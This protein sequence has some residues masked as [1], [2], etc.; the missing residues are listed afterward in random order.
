MKINNTLHY[1]TPCSSVLLSF[2]ISMFANVKYV[3]GLMRR[4]FFSELGLQE[5]LM[6]PLPKNWKPCKTKDTEDI[7][8]FNFSTG[9][10]TWDHPCDGYYK[11]LYEEEKKKKETMKKESNDM[12]RTE[13]KKTVEKLTGKADRKKK[14]KEQKDSVQNSSDSLGSIQSKSASSLTKKPLPDIRPKLSSLEPSLGSTSKTSLGGSASSLSMNRQSVESTTSV[15]SDV[16]SS[17]DD[18]PNASISSSTNSRHVSKLKNVVS[19]SEGEGS[20][21]HDQDRPYSAPSGI[22]SSMES[23]SKSDAREPSCFDAKGE[24]LDNQHD[25]YESHMRDLKRSFQEEINKMNNKHSE[26]LTNLELNFQ[27]EINE[28]NEKVKQRRSTLHLELEKVEEEHKEREKRYRVKLEDIIRAE[29][30]LQRRED[31]HEEKKNDHQDE[32]RSKEAMITSLKATISSLEEDSSRQKDRHAASLKE[33]TELKAIEGN[34]RIQLRELKDEVEEMNTENKRLI[35]Q[36]SAHH[37]HESSNP[38]SSEELLRN[39]LDAEKAISEASNKQIKE[40]ENKLDKITSE[41]ERALSSVREE[42]AQLQVRLEAEISTLKASNNSKGAEIEAGLAK[43]NRLTLELNNAQQDLEKSKSTIKELRNHHVENLPASSS[44]DQV[45]V[46]QEEVELLK[47]ENS[48]LLSNHH[49]L[50]VQEGEKLKILEEEKANVIKLLEIEKEG[51]KVV[52]INEKEYKDKIEDLLAQLTQKNERLTSLQEKHEEMVAAGSSTENSLMTLSMENSRSLVEINELKEQLRIKDEMVVTKDALLKELRF[53]VSTQSASSNEDGDIKEMLEVKLNAA[54]EKV[55]ELSTE[56]SKLRGTISV[57]VREVEDLKN[58]RAVLESK[59]YD[60]E[61]EIVVLRASESAL[62][63]KLDTTEQTIQSLEMTRKL[64]DNAS[65]TQTD[66]INQ[67]H[68]KYSSEIVALTKELESLKMEKGFMSNNLEVIHSKYALVETERSS[69]Q[70]ENNTLRSKTAGYLNEISNLK[71]SLNTTKTESQDVPHQVA[72]AGA[73]IPPVAPES[74]GSH[75]LITKVAGHEEE[76][77][78]LKRH[79]LS[80]ENAL[81]RQQNSVDLLSSKL[82]ETEHLIQNISKQRE[83]PKTSDFNK[84]SP[85]FVNAESDLKYV[86]QHDLGG[87]SD[88]RDTS[89]ANEVLDDFFQHE[90]FTDRRSN[91]VYKNGQELL[92]KIERENRFIENAIKALAKDKDYIRSVQTQLEKRRDEW[93]RLKRDSQ[94]SASRQMML[95][96]SE[97]LNKQTQEVNNLVRESKRFKLWII[98]RKKKVEELEDIFYSEKVKNGDNDDKDDA[99][100]TV[101]TDKS[102]GIIRKLDEELENYYSKLRLDMGVMPSQDY[103]DTDMDGLRPRRFSSWQAQIMSSCNKENERIINRSRIPRSSSVFMNNLDSA[104]IDVENIVVARS[105]MNQHYLQHANWL[106]KMRQEMTFPIGESA[107]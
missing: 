21:K 56:L 45:K 11:R 18:N 99:P 91:K 14:K 78:N 29:E 73:V 65:T 70:A 95:K 92:M 48:S 30:D 60:M 25:E 24:H 93:K 106:D 40:I 36:V 85:Y 104:R 75:T 89:R 97:I 98:A 96:T 102:L 57:K 33:V 20:L 38:S 22:K 47:K 5:G 8:Y 101:D 51:R 42:K 34:L 100:N 63:S 13:A 7:Y 67:I 69:L 26:M 37:Q 4:L 76:I 28:H 43:I 10:S 88:I 16:S 105:N 74:V 61:K 32:L 77:L 62:R 9:E 103:L 41:N 68:D 71:K 81:A 80:I 44:T 50:K 83:M 84:E 66:T 15:R 6:A 49:T 82:A 87:D 54:N 72:I 59:N 2:N 27:K 17:F 35:A 52:D 107:L 94:G 31:V 39:R 53:Q 1:H 3:R 90:Y 55:V 64:N 23:E 19:F 46:L 86:D 79:K 12:Q 58:E